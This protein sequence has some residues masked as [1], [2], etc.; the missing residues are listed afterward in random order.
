MTPPWPDYVAEHRP[1]IRRVVGR[2]V[3]SYVVDDLTQDAIVMALRYPPR[4]RGP[5]NQGWLR[6]TAE[7]IVAAWWAVNYR[8]WDIDD[9]FMPAN[10][11]RCMVLDTG[12]RIQWEPV[13][14]SSDSLVPLEALDELCG[15]LS[16]LDD[17]SRR[18]LWMVGAGWSLREVGV[19]LGI[20]EG[21]AKVLVMRA[22]RQAW[23]DREGRE[24]RCRAS[25]QDQQEARSLRAMGLSIRAVAM[26]MGM[27]VSTVGD[28]LRG[29]PSTELAEAA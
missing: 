10:G 2:K 9:A 27:P 1:Y 25:E 12:H 14:H 24:L 6:V 16:G 7:K 17:R 3:P 28:M 26:R 18:A 23:P 20:T 11:R 21:A 29:V 4:V 13:A 5:Q 15:R 22:R 8:E 19:A